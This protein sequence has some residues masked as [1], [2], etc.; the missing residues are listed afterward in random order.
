[1]Q[2]FAKISSVKGNKNLEIQNR[3]RD[4]VLESL[5]SSQD[6]K[7]SYQQLQG[8]EYME[9]VFHEVLRLWQ[10]LALNQR[11]CTQDYK[12]P[13]TDLTLKA[14]EE[15]FINVIGF[16]RDPKHFPNPDEF[17]PD[18]FSKEAKEKRHP[19][20]YMGFGHGP[21]NCIGM[22]FALLEAKLVMSSVLQNFEILWCSNSPSTLTP[23]IDGLLGAP[24]EPL[25]VNI[26]RR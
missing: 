8:L 15:I 5:D 23:N 11:A 4:E 12:I 2:E 24:K 22:R 21:R 7:L 13:G 16:H 9:Q 17:N 14:G 6:G 26:R 18:N 3:A 25:T 19:Y 10:P 1:M 20:A